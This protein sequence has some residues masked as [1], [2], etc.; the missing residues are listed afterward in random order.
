MKKGTLILINL[1][2]VGPGSTSAFGSYV[3]LGQAKRVGIWFEGSYA[4]SGG[5]AACLD[6]YPA[7]A[8][9]PGSIDT[10]PIGSLVLATGA[11]VTKR[12]TKQLG[13]IEAFSHI[14]CK[15]RHQSGP[16]GIIAKAKAI[17]QH[18]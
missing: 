18:N 2:R 10:A 15:V 13:S 3:G 1:S 14:V 8:P 17:V 16:A 12:R 6:V 5:T 9:S 4:S 7:I 11:N